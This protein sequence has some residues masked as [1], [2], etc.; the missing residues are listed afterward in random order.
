MVDTIVNVNKTDVAEVYSSKV[1]LVM[2]ARRVFGER[3]AAQLWMAIGLPMV[4]AMFRQRTQ[5]DLL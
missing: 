3:A 5:G 4:P 2:E 1:K